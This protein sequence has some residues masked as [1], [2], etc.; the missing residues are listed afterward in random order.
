MNKKP[1][2][3]PVAVSSNPANAGFLLDRTWEG[4]VS[5]HQNADHCCISEISLSTA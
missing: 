4:I 1:P 2:T 3:N 5:S